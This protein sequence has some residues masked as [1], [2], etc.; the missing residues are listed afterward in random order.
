MALTKFF[1]TPFS[2]AQHNPNQANGANKKG[3]L[4]HALES[5]NTTPHPNPALHQAT[6]GLMSPLTP[7]T[8]RPTLSSITEEP[9]IDLNHNT[10]VSTLRSLSLQALDLAKLAVNR[11][12]I[13]HAAVPFLSGVAGAAFIPT[14]ESPSVMTHL[15]LGAFFSLVAVSSANRIRDEIPE[16][17]A[18]K[19]Y[20]GELI[21]G[22]I[23]GALAATG[24]KAP[25][26]WHTHLIAISIA[27][28]VINLLN[29]GWRETLSRHITFRT[30]FQA[31]LA[32]SNSAD[33]GRVA[34]ILG[35]AA[36]LN[37]IMHSA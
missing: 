20:Y 12:G 28:E 26:T 15:T 5:V 36:F 1:K 34:L 10:S 21:V 18:D 19:V 14:E 33:A 24:Y 23:A 31:G 2:P 6:T 16:Y 27:G 32:V 7:N 29:E 4:D 22:H 17:S 9:Y 30:A 37:N 3:T 11:E 13:L 8:A 25:T 35:V